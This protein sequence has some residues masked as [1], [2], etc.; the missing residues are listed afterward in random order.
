MN[1]PLVY[2]RVDASSQIGFGHF[3]RCTALAHMLKENFDLRFI[4]YALPAALLNQTREKGFKVSIIQVEKQFLS[5]LRGT[6]IV[7]LDGYEFNSAYQKKIKSLGCRLV[8]ID[9]LHNQEFFADLII[10][11]APSTTSQ[12]YL[13]QEYTQYAL[14]LN[15]ALLRP[16]FLEIAKRNRVNNSNELFICFGGSDPL[17]LTRTVLTVVLQ[18][19]I[20]A[21]I[22]VVIGE[23]YKNPG[24]L[25]KY[26][27]PESNIIIYRSLNEEEMLSVMLQAEFAIV[28]SSG[29]LLESLAIGLKLISGMYADNQRLVYENFRNSGMFIDAG[30]FEKTK[31]EVGIKML[32]DSKEK[33]PEKVIDG[34]SSYRILKAFQLMVNQDALNLRRVMPSDLEQTFMWAVNPN[35]R[36]HSFNNK[37][38]KKEEHTEWFHNKINN[39]ESCY[40]YIAEIENESIGSIRFDVRANNAIISFLVD[41][42]YQGRGFGYLL[43]QKGFQK[44]KEDSKNI[45]KVIGYVLVDNTPSIKSFIKLGYKSVLENEGQRYKFIKKINN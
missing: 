1:K 3:I 19:N 45:N 21:K 39:T 14:G 38:I 25:Q 4:S 35:I 12:D 8:C 6:E 13:A 33:L 23:G 16:A 28:P 31:L 5:S 42:A 26:G 27:G 18:N 40:F 34:N 15:Y 43:L 9:D 22:H 44:L 36:R 29:I 37:R 20:F 32:K 11:H 17:N 7:V 2:I 10:N 30:N 41:P 24:D